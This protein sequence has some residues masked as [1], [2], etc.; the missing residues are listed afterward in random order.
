MVKEGNLNICLDNKVGHV[1]VCIPEEGS[2]ITTHTLPVCKDIVPPVYQLTELG[3][4][5]IVNF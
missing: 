2:D 5:E 4:W 3:T 1:G